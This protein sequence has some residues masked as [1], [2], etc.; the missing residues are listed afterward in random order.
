MYNVTLSSRKLKPNTHSV[1]Q[2][3]NGIHFPS[4][5]N[6]RKWLG[7]CASSVVVVRSQALLGTQNTTTVL[8]GIV[9]VDM[10]P[11]T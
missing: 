11:I 6:I 10:T 9:I 5:E 4:V 3:C 2:Q 8:Q 7:W 1:G